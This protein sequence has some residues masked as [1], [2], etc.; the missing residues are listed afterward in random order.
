MKFRVFAAALVLVGGQHAETA[1]PTPIGIPRIENLD[2]LD[3]FDFSASSTL[4]H[5]CLTD[6]LLSLPAGRHPGDASEDGRAD[7]GGL[8]GGAG[9][10]GGG[11][12]MLLGLNT[13]FSGFA[14]H[15]TNLAVL[16]SGAGG[17]SSP[18]SSG[19]DP[20]CSPCGSNQDVVTVPGPIVGA[21]LPSLMLAGAGL[22][23]WWRRKRKAEAATR[24][25]PQ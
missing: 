12:N 10:F 8:G 22:L 25:L 23:G 14:V 19:V 24:S 9:G 1:L 5:P 18:G 13:D 15:P 17:S 21:G 6:P 7:F 4:I 16:S 11:G 2:G 20:N 3:Q